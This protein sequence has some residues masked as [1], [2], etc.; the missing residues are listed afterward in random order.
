MQL[1]APCSAATLLHLLSGPVLPHAWARNKVP[2]RCNCATSTVW[3]EASFVPC[4][5]QMADEPSVGSCMI[6]CGTA[7][8]SPA[9]VPTT[10][11]TTE[12]RELTGASSS[13]DQSW[14]PAVGETTTLIELGTVQSGRCPTGALLVD[15]VQSHLGD[16]GCYSS[17]NGALL[18]LPLPGPASPGLGAD[19][20]CDVARFPKLEHSGYQTGPESQHEGLLGLVWP[21]PGASGSYPGHLQNLGWK[22]PLF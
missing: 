19:W 7:R 4:A 16:G 6:R 11:I 2:P 8:P 5:Q 3:P 14:G 18:S 9:R 22:F 21:C 1:C 10:A 13:L 15:S 17:Q 12:P 20:Q